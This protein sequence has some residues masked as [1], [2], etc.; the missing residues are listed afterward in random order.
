MTDQSYQFPRFF[1]TAPQP[2]PYIDGKIERKVFTDLVGKDATELN[3]ALGRVGFRRSQTV[4]YRPACEQCS[5]CVSVRVVAQDFK[6]NK[7]QRRVIKN[8]THLVA[9][10]TDLMATNEQYELLKKYLE[11]RHQDGGMTDMDEYEYSEM[12]LKSP[13]TTTIVEYRLPSDDDKDPL[14]GLLIGAALTD[15]L[16]DGLSMVYSFFDPEYEN[17]S[18]GN[19]MILDHIERVKVSDLTHVYLGYWV[20]ESQKMNYKTKFKPIEALSPT[21]WALLED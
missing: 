13:V 14:G 11:H 5:S 7:S 12:V 9:I 18:L 6:A 19:Y 17:L 15:V 10:A 2:C 3:E 8:N 16:T 1:M 4:A 21:G 20:K